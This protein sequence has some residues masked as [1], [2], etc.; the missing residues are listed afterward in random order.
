MPVELYGTKFAV[1][2]PLRVHLSLYA[3]PEKREHVSDAWLAEN[4]LTRE[5]LIGPEADWMFL[6]AAMQCAYG[7]KRGW[8]WHIGMDQ[9][10]LAW[11]TNRRLCIVGPTRVTKSYFFGALMVI[12]W[13]SDPADTSW[14]IYSTTI[15]ALRGRVWRSVG[16][17]WGYLEIT[18]PWVKEV[19]KIKESNPPALRHKN[20][21]SES[22]ILAI[23]MDDKI[24]TEEDL[25]ARIGTHN[26]KVRVAGDEI[27]GLPA[28]VLKLESNLGGSKF[29]K[30]AVWGNFGGERTALG[31]AAHPPE[32][33][34]Q[35]PQG[36][37]KGGYDGWRDIAQRTDS[38][39]LNREPKPEEWTSRNPDDPSKPFFRV[40][41][42][43]GLRTPSVLH[44]EGPAMGDKLYGHFMLGLSR[45]NQYVPGTYSWWKMVRSAPM[46]VGDQEVCLSDAVRTQY[47]VE[48]PVIWLKPDWRW[49][50]GADG[51]R[52]GDAN[53]LCAVRSGTMKSGQ[54]VISFEWCE[55]FSPKAEGD[56][57]MQIVQWI[58]KKLESAGADKSLLAVEGAVTSNLSS[59]WDTLDR[60]WSAPG[61]LTRVSTQHK[62]F[63]EK[64]LYVNEGN[65]TPVNKYY[66]HVAAFMWLMPREFARAGMLR[67]LGDPEILQ[68]LSLRK[69]YAES[70]PV[71]IQAKE[72]AGRP[73]PGKFRDFKDEIGKSPNRTDAFTLALLHQRL[74]HGVH[75]GAPV[76]SVAGHDDGANPGGRTM[77]AKERWKQKAKVINARTTAKHHPGARRTISRRFGGKGSFDWLFPDE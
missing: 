9:I 32:D 67:N 35:C 44:P 22:G 41:W 28:I 70:D 2:C 53:A 6:K 8:V 71:E 33:L 37:S 52:L 39:D 27:Q 10:G 38:I 65:R 69:V 24:K 49:S 23:A 64:T 61:K 31:I 50:Y 18:F 59:L 15:D 12:D 29:Y 47:R 72:T 42:L 48:S 46:P 25:N 7:K 73:G 66:G 30:E 62:T 56:V 54:L 17:H 14:F 40:L 4:N 63:P 5:Q 68:H 76:V 43:D 34:E 13:L 36:W 60:T 1:D 77:P 58:M 3:H 75:P 26:I 19:G 11:C 57:D 45:I 55:E 21:G 51:G 20:V 74:H 16:E